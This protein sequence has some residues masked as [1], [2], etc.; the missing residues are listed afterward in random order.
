MCLRLSCVIRLPAATEAH[1]FD[2]ETSRALTCHRTHQKGTQKETT[3]KKQSSGVA[4][5][6][7]RLFF[8]SNDQACLQ[9]EPPW[10]QLIKSR[11]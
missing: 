2:E 7:P 3:K 10:K 8:L 6:R 4:D 5:K 1:P 11:Q 9:S